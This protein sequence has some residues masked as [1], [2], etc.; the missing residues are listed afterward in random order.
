MLIVTSYV[1]T[2][3]RGCAQGVAARPL[4]SLQK[5]K[6][7]PAVC[8]TGCHHCAQIP[9]YVPAGLPHLQQGPLT[10]GRRT[11]VRPL[12]RALWSEGHGKPHGPHACLLG[13]LG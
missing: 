10:E 2:T 11:Q 9:W 6:W 7:N 5:P 12:D 1:F 3:I 4:A 8:H 13:E